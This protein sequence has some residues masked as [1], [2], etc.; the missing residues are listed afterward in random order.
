MPKSLRTSTILTANG[1]L[2]LLILFSV[3]L[4]IHSAHNVIWWIIGAFTVFAYILWELWRSLAKNHPPESKTLYQSLGLPTQITLTRGFLI[5]VVGGFV[6]F[7]ITEG[8]MRWV[9]GIAYLLTAILDALDGYA[10]RKL[11]R[12]TQLGQILDNKFDALGTLIAVLL[13]ITLGKLPLWYIIVGIAYYLFIAGQWLRRRLDRTVYDLHQDRRRSVFAGIQ[14]AFL[15]IVIL[16]V[17]SA[18]STF[19]AAVAF[20]IPTAFMFA[21]DWLVTSGVLSPDEDSYQRKADF[22]R[23]LLSFM[24]LPVLRLVLFCTFVY[25][26]ILTAR[27]TAFPAFGLSQ[28]VVAAIIAGCLTLILFGFGGRVAAAAALLLLGAVAGGVSVLS[29]TGILFF[30]VIIILLFGTGKFSLW[31]PEEAILFGNSHTD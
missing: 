10:A 13:G 24:L 9:P 15:G 4:S 18:E 23:N 22:A 17:Y 3:E 31:Q 28:P 25:S 20:F 2:F 26:C 11:D 6:L 30:G 19:L 1:Y 7:P 27:Y 14:M 29:V 16:P 12:I 5:A 21:R 8:W